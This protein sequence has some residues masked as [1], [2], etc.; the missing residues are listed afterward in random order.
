MP[1]ASASSPR[2]IRNGAPW[3]RCGACMRATSQRPSRRCTAPAGGPHAR[4]QPPRSRSGSGEGRGW[5]TAASGRRS[6]AKRATSARR[7]AASRSSAACCSAAGASAG[8]STFPARTAA[9]SKP[10]PL[11]S[12]SRRH[13]MAAATAKT[14]RLR[15]RPD[16]CGGRAGASILLAREHVPGAPHR[17]E[18]AGAL[19]IV[20]DGGADARDVDVDRAVER[21]ERLAAHKVHEGVP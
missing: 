4:S 7:L 11:P 21:L 19:G 15:G 17:E 3:G 12:P 14:T 6:G 8:G 5:P 16:R 20:L 10:A 13:T 9:A 1:T 18:P 2:V